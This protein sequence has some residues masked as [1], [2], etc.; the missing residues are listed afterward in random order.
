MDSLRSGTLDSAT[1]VQTLKVYKDA[2]LAAIS[3]ALLPSHSY[4]LLE[5][6]Y[7]VFLPPQHRLSAHFLFVLV[8]QFHNGH[9]SNWSIVAQ[10]LIVFPACSSD[11]CMWREERI[12]VQG[13]YYTRII[14]A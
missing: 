7:P 6:I 12:C 10:S 3:L 4:S 2:L 14:T 5:S 11:F 13:L 8:G 1:S 9:C